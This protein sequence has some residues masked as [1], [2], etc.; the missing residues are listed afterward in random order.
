MYKGF[1]EAIY[2]FS[3]N[4]IQFFGGS[5]VAAILFWFMTTFGFV[6]VLLQFSTS[7]FS[8]YLALLILTRII[9]SLV[10]RQAILYNLL[11]AIPQQ[12][13]MG[14]FIYQAIINSFKKQYTWKDRKISA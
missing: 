12:L 14:L 7:I 3:K 8:A 6:V 9:V 4:V 5:L 10:S 1:E 11:L 13:V 2:G